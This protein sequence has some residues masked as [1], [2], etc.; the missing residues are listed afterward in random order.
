MP[1]ARDV[2]MLAMKQAR[3]LAPGEEPSADEAADGLKLLQGLYDAWW[4]GGMFGQLYDTVYALS[5]TAAPFD[6]AQHAGTVIVT[7]PT[8][9][10][11]D[12]GLMPPYDLSPIELFNTTTLALSRYLFDATRGAWVNINALTLD[13]EAP[14]ASRGID[15]LAA[16]LSM[17]F[18]EMFGEQLGPMT[19]RRAGLF[20]TA[21]SMKLGAERT[22]TEVAWF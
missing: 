1:T 9:V 22:H 13:S 8:Q 4:T 16:C 21:L 2:I 11:N 17:S 12:N 3:V 19:A 10:D 15:G 6:R 18:A 7:L 5:Q 14:L 20:K